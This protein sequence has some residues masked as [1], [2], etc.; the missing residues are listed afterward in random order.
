[1]TWIDC[2]RWHILTGTVAALVVE[3]A[4]NDAFTWSWS[5]WVSIDG[6]ETRIRAGS[7]KGTEEGAK[8]AASDELRRAASNLLA[9]ARAAAVVGESINR[10]SAEVVT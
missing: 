1:M 3:H 6:R 5:V 8:Q 10:A 9:D 2:G 7:H 4:E